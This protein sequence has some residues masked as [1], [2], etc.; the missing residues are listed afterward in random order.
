[1]LTN[2]MRTGGWFPT[3]FDD[4]LNTDFMPRANA[5]APAV[6]VKEDDK[7]Y[8]MEIAAPGIKKEFCRV[9]IN[10][11]G[12]LAIAIENKTEHKENDHKNHYLR[13]EFSYSN[14]EQSYTLPDDVEK[15]DI[16]AKVENGIL[17]VILPKA[18]KEVKKISKNI[19]IA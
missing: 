16:S 14:Y 6:N 12:N 9:S 10:D 18:K 2:L 5:T 3:V 13:R 7:A 15:E 8:T 17:T 4:F 1:M 11:D 19:A